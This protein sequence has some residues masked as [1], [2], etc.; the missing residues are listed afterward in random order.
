M[1]S[2]CRVKDQLNTSEP[3]AS[4]IIGR[5]LKSQKTSQSAVE[6]EPMT[7]RIAATDDDKD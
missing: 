3:I 2:S 4:Y 1:N 6:V 5:E 7:F